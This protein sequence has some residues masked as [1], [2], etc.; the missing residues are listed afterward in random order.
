MDEY[1]FKLFSEGIVENDEI[2]VKET[3]TQLCTKEQKSRNRH[4]FFFKDIVS[5]P[6]QGYLKI[7]WLNNMQI[8]IDNEFIHNEII[9]VILNKKYEDNEA[10]LMTKMIIEEPPLNHNGLIGKRDESKI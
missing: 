10:K 8:K 4:S 3:I 6:A 7:A 9:P 2:K 1:R 5:H